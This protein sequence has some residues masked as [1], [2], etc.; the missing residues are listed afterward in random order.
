MR[1]KTTRDGVHDQSRRGNVL[2]AEDR[3]AHDRHARS[4]V[5]D[6]DD[7]G[8]LPHAAAVRAHVHGR[9]QHR[10]HSPIVIHRALLGSLERFIGIL[11]EHYGGAFPLW[12]AP[13]QV[14]IIPVGEDHREDARKVAD[15]LRE[16]GFR[17]KQ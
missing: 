9:G 3:P 6:G 2:R 8:R 13:I 12:L 15:L 14:R 11:I 17:V 4:F 10:E 16:H 7:P 5:A 1:W